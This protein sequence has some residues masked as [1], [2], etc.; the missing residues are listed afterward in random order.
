MIPTAREAPRMGRPRFDPVGLAV[1]LALAALIGWPAA[2]TVSAARAGPG[3]PAVGGGGLMDPTPAG[4]AGRPLGLALATGEVTLLA[5]AIAMAL[6]VPLA[7][8]LVRTDLPGRRALA[9][10]LATALFVPLPLQATAWLGALGNLGRAQAIG[11]RPLLVGLPGAAFVHAMAALPWAVLLV[12]LGLMTVEREL[13]ESALLDRPA[14]WVVRR[15]ALRRSLG[16]LLAAATAVAVL[17]A[18]DMT[19]TDLVQVRT[20]AEEAYVQYQLGGGPAAASRVALPPLV[21][22]GGL[23]ALGAAVA[24]R[25]DPRR[26]LSAAPPRR[27]ALGRW[28]APAGLAAWLVAGVAMGLPVAALIWRAGRVAGD[29]ASGRAPRWSPGGLAGT[30]ARAWPDVAEPSALAADPLRSPLLVTL[31]LAAVAA[32]LAVAL[33]WPLAWRAA[34]GGAGWKA[35]AALVAATLWAAPAPVV[36]MALKLAYLP[37]PIVHDT[38]AIVVLAYVAR[39]LPYALCVLF[40]ALYAIPPAYLE[41]AALDGLG[42]GG[43]ARRVAWPIARPAALT[44]WALCAALALGELPASNLVLPPGLT[45]L[46]ARVW[47]LLHTGVESHL[48]GVA[49]WLLLVYALAG[50]AVAALA[51]RLARAA[52][53]HAPTSGDHPA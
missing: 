1:L 13:E 3:D 2:A 43:R 39:T 14:G 46:S 16:A 49:L 41:A 15:V 37:V 28:R 53:P 11:S 33:A 25:A 7:L 31:A 12:G 30:L 32:T 51:R 48:A 38:A 47:Q 34:R 22:L 23:I 20:Y 42:P 50:A 35:L 17:T 52:S 9:A 44:A 8:A 40:P 4:G 5:V 36:G 29:A 19:V 10:L 26:R 24:M 27:W 45:T 6:G 18:G 21:V